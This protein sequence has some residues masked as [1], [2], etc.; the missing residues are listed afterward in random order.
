MPPKRK[1]EHSNVYRQQ[2]HLHTHKLN[3]SLDPE[4]RSNF[5][6]TEKKMVVRGN[7]LLDVIFGDSWA[8]EPRLIIWM[9]Y[10][11]GYYF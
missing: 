8:F 10:L 1:N 4:S 5:Q 9:I 3:L 2:T 6:L 7:M 11:R